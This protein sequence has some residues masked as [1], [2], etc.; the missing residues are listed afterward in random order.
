MKDKQVNI[1]F[2]MMMKIDCCKHKGF[3]L[4]VMSCVTHKISDSKDKCT[5]SIVFENSFVNKMAI[6]QIPF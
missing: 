3:F 4:L 5:P 6:F 2:I 1:N